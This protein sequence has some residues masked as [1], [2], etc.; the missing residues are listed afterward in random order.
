MNEQ[1]RPQNTPPAASPDPPAGLPPS[2]RDLAELGIVTAV[3]PRSLWP[4]DDSWIFVCRDSS[5]RHLGA[6]GPTGLPRPWSGLVWTQRVDLAD[7][8]RF[9]KGP[10]SGANA[11]ALRQELDWCRPMV[12]GYTDSF[13]FGDRLGLASP[14]HLRVLDGYQVK[15]VLAQQSVRELERTRRTADEVLDAATVAV[16]QEGFRL[17]FGADADHLKQPADVVRFAQAGYTMFTFDP[18]DAVVA[19]ADRLSLE[20]AREHAVPVLSSV[21]GETVAACLDAFA[22][23]D[24]RLADGSSLRPE[25]GDVLKAVV[26]YGRVV[27]R[28]AELN[29]VLAGV[30]STGSYEVELSVDETDSPTTPF[31]HFWLVRSLKRLGVRLASLAPRFAG[32]MEKGVDFR[33]RLEDFRRDW[34]R[35]AAVARTLGPYK[36]SLHSG[37]DKFS[38]YPVLAE[39]PSAFHVKTAGTSYLEA[40]RAAGRIEPQLLAEILD[41]SRELYTETRHSYHVSAALD[42][43]P[44]SA[45][46]QP[47]QLAA[48]LDDDD[49]RQ[50][51]HVA[52]GAVLSATESDGSSRF[53]HRLVQLLDRN[54]ETHFSFLRDRFVRHLEPLAR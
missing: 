23:R 27:A 17:G 42:R 11:D 24:L 28:V 52:F 20:E 47:G 51:F 41:F 46:L 30:R 25:A 33:G 49:A 12:I 40:L 54:E 2:V 14:G 32:A 21:L 5:G 29:K 31:E 10:L 36:L 48:L 38:L 16:F 39:H 45:G 3:Y 8:R 7:G 50:V 43:V 9:W 37:S 6:V 19:D 53:R 26:K 15:P 18:G 35:H 1:K 34:H 22:G 44:P 4:A 13:G